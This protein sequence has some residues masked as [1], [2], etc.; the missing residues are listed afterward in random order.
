MGKSHAKS[1]GLPTALPTA[2]CDQHPTRSKSEHSVTAFHDDDIDERNG[3]M[4][5]LDPGAFADRLR[6]LRIQRGLTQQEL[7]VQAGL[8]ARSVS[9]LERGINQRP[10]RDTAV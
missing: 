5:A 4:S 6:Y 9:D 3:Q 8:S 10:R 1:T 2:F 7:A